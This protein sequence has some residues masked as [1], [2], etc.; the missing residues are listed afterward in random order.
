MRY[1]IT[2]QNT[3]NGG[4]IHKIERFDKYATILEP[5]DKRFAPQQIV[6]NGKEKCYQ[7]IYELKL[8]ISLSE[9]K[10]IFKDTFRY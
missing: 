8:Y 5:N 3:N 7:F 10:D 4:L 2:Y 9:A 6:I 1:V